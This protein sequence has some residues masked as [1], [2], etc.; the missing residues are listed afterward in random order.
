MMQFDELGYL[1]SRVEARCASLGIGEERTDAML[2]AG[3]GTS[4]KATETRLRIVDEML[5]LVTDVFG[6]GRGADWLRHHG[7]TFGGATPLDLATGG[8]SGVRRVRDHL[9]I[10]HDVLAD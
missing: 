8:L 9:R 5:M 7:E 10:L 2:D 1:R 3:F 4:A 6:V